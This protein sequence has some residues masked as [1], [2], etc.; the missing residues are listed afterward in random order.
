[1]GTC[2]F[3]GGL[4]LYKKTVKDTNSVID[5]FKGQWQYYV[6]G[7]SLIIYLVSIFPFF[8]YTTRSQVY[9]ILP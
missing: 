1:M 2:G 3:L 8:P 6:L 7:V 4:A 5:Y 9:Q